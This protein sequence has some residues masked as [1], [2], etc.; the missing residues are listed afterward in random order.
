M[1]AISTPIQTPKPSGSER[2]A[3]YRISD[4]VALKLNKLDPNALNAAIDKIKRQ[5]FELQALASK[6]GADAQ[7]QS[8][9]RDVEAKLPEVANLFR[10]FEQRIDALVNVI[11][12][13]NI[14]S[15]QSPNAVVSISGNGL[16]F[17]WTSAFYEGEHLAVEMTLFPSRVHIEAVAKVV[18]GNPNE[19]STDGHFHC[20][21][22]FVEIAHS[23][24]EQLLQHVH[25]LQIQALRSRN[26]S[27]Y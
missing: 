14:A 6:G 19:R 27:D 10:L 13:Q 7:F 9:L 21:L 18:R 1:P 22:E 26:D 11:A 5:E 25:Q 23:N 3:F 8:A 24:R 2:R 12:S 15:E 20:A 16:A 17:D 4:A